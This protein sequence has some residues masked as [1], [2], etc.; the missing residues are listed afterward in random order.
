[1]SQLIAPDCSQ[2]EVS[3]FGPG[4]GES[5]VVHLGNG[6]WVIIDSCMDEVLQKPKPITYLTSL[7]VDVANDVVL[8]VATHWH[9]DHIG[10]IASILRDCSSAKFSCSMVFAHEK[11]LTLS[12]L[13]ASGIQ[14][15]TGMN[16]LEAVYTI[17]EERKIA[18]V[19][20]NAGRLLCREIV[21]G[22]IK[23]NANLHS[24]SP[25]DEAVEEYVRAVFRKSYDSTD[26]LLKAQSVAPNHSSVVIQL[27]TGTDSV[28]LGSDMENHGRFGWTSVLND[29]T[30]PLEQSFAYKVAHHGS[31][32]GHNDNV[33]K[34]MVSSNAT[35]FL[36]PFQNGR[37]RIPTEEDRKRIRELSVE[38]F[39][40]TASPA[41]RKKKHTYNRDVEKTIKEAGINI[42]QS[43][44]SPGHV[45]L[46]YTPGDLGS[47][48][49]NLYD[50]AAEL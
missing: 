14:K 43:P 49:I 44:V 16:E 24:L 15:E 19:K 39:T 30:R 23:Y 12:E 4:F 40:T 37:T 32:S 50:G 5:V 7:G 45:R 8:I 18:P 10:G 20:A 22:D 2:V 34:E 48:S 21:D 33:W 1:M 25:S 42:R 27:V 31:I 28:L 47:R 11:M 29:S 46:R 3:L 36:T 41:F 6:K 13:Y 26:Y 9:D 35:S 38:S 17:L